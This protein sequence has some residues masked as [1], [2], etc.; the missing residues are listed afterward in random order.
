MFN[1]TVEKIVSNKNRNKF[2]IKISL[3][4]FVI[5]LLSW[6]AIRIMTLVIIN[7][8]FENIKKNSANN[9]KQRIEYNSRID[10]LKSRIVL[11]NIAITLFP[12]TI[13]IDEILVSKNSGFIFPSSLKVSIKGIDTTT[14]QGK[15]YFIVNNDGEYTDFYV[16]LKTPLFK[17]PTYKGFYT[18]KNN[19]FKMSEENKEIG[20]L[21]L[22]KT[23]IQQMYDGKSNVNY[24]GEVIFHDGDFIPSLVLIDRPFKW[25][26]QFTEHSV[27]KFKSDSSSDEYINYLDAKNILLDFD[28]ASAK[29]KGNLSY[30]NQLRTADFKIEIKNDKQLFSS[31]LNMVIQTNEDNIGTFKK[32][33][34]TV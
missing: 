6:I 33:Y 7:K 13:D 30:D 29:M 20:K 24:S 5:L 12:G 16:S 32:L 1:S 17:I 10:W 34:K 26:F 31:I 14:Q 4:F 25:N 21:T 15:Q 8:Y 9:E 28:F 18:L 2:L 19:I 3:V 22:N 23:T 11:S 27:K